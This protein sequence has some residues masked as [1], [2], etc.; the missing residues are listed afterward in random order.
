MLLAVGGIMGAVG[1]VALFYQTTNKVAI[2]H[3]IQINSLLLIL[4]A[5]GLIIN[6]VHELAEKVPLISTAKT[7]HA[8]VTLLPNLPSLLE[9]ITTGFFGWKRQVTMIEALAYSCYLIWM[10][11]R[12]RTITKATNG[13][14]DP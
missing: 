2:R 12:L 14:L 10:A 4:F 8:S 6:G 11:R 3:V 7:L 5:G 9:F 13:H 1:V